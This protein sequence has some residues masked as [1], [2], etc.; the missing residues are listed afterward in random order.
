MKPETFAAIPDQY[1]TTI[2]SDEARD[3]TTIGC[4]R[5]IRNEPGASIWVSEAPISC[6]CWVNDG[7]VSLQLSIPRGQ[8]L[9]LLEGQGL[10]MC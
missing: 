6:C 3:G 10:R 8:E 1:V 4:M 7:L 2:V 9:R 5:W